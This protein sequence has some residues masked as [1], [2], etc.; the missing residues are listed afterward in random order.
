MFFMR[1]FAFV[2]KE[3]IKIPLDTN[4]PPV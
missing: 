1:L 3:I 4:P 2:L